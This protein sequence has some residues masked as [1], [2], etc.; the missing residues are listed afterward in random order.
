MY[1]GFVGKWR[2]GLDWRLQ[3]IGRE[4][5]QLRQLV[6][7]E[8]GQVPGQSVKELVG[9]LKA[10]LAQLDAE[11]KPQQLAGEAEL[12]IRT[13]E[14]IIANAEGRHA[15]A[16]I[17]LTE[18][19][20]QQARRAAGPGQKAQLRRVLCIRA[21]ALYHLHQWSDALER[22][23]EVSRSLPNQLPVQ[24]RMAICLEG[25]GRAKE[26]VSA[27][28]ELAKAENIQGKTF[29]AAGKLERA[30]AA[31]QMGVQV[32]AHL[33]TQT[34]DS[35]LTNNL[36]MSHMYLGH[37]FLVQGNA[38]AA[39][40]QYQSAI[41]LLQPLADQAQGELADKLAVSF[42]HAGDALLVEGKVEPALDHF[43]RGLALLTRLVE[44]Q[45][46]NELSTELALCYNNRGVVRRAQG[47]L[48]DA[49]ADFDKAIGILKGASG[50]STAGKP[51]RTSQGSQGP[52]SPDVRLSIAV[53]YSESGIDLLRRIWVMS[54]SSQQTERA[55]ALAT[56]VKNRGYAHLVQGNVEAALRELNEASELY[57]PMADQEEL[58]FQLA[59]TLSSAAWIYATYPESVVR[60]GVKAKQYALKACELS[61]WKV[62][63][64]LE[65]LA[66]ACAET[67]DFAQAIK[68]Q[69]MALEL[70]P[71]KQSREITARLD[72]YKSGNPY[73]ARPPKAK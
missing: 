16:L 32:Q 11:Y 2:A 13:A 64:P 17:K 70:A 60:D 66:A 34:T 56:S 5:E 48:D 27:Y 20:E 63:V 9:T 51:A 58:A 3:E 19:D 42:N 7:D 35:E 69:Q 71:A 73:R 41:G 23:Q 65:S 49:L 4:G 47:K 45:Q 68:W 36:A 38:P 53:G 55:V 46:H 50:N 54:E 14:A 43:E 12:R 57:S 1:A 22:Y 25:L 72:L 40:A 44:Q 61:N 15:D 67:G 39:A 52:F 26:A 6:E 37:T 8:P 33:L 30:R 28:T 29:L 59:K 10:R 21:D 18:Q 62:S 24:A 31:F